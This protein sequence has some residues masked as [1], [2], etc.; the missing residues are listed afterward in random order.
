MMA[1]R[2]MADPYHFSAMMVREGDADGLVSGALRNYADCVKPILQI[3]D[4]DVGSLAS[5]LNIV[6]WKNKMM[7]FADTTVNINPTAEDLSKIAYYAAKVSRYFKQEPKI[8]MV[9]FSNFAGQQ[10]NPRKMQKAAQ[11]FKSHHPEAVVEGELQAD[12]AVNPD[13]INRLFPFSEL[14]DGANILIFPNLDASNAAYKLVQQMGGG[15]VLGPFLMGL[16]KPANVLQRTGTVEDV[17]NT[18][19]LTALECQA[20]KEPQPVFK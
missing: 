13:I 5:G 8:A 14:K 6:L 19:V 12:A 18:I 2:L 9:S 15:E 4:T 10:E 3:I 1:E 11:I 20:F 16:K 7:F 17:I